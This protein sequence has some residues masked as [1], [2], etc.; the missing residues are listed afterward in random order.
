MFSMISLWDGTGNQNPSPKEDHLS[1]IVNI[2]ITDDMAMQGAE[3]S[4]AAVLT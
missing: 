1:C 4:A 2:I 3:A